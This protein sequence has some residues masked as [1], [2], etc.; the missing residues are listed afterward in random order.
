LKPIGTRPPDIS[1]QP[2]LS[3]VAVT[4]SQRGDD[5]LDQLLVQCMIVSGNLVSPED[6][7]STLKS[8]FGL[9]MG[10]ERVQRGLERLVAQRQ[11]TSS[12]GVA[13]FGVSLAL[14]GRIEA[15]IESAK[16]LEYRVREKWLA[17]CAAVFTKLD[18]DQ[19]WICLQRYL[20]MLFR[21]HGLQTV[22]LL[23][24]KAEQSEEHATLLKS[25]LDDALTESCGTGEQRPLVE[26]SIRLFLATVGSDLDRTKF[27]VQLADGAFSYYS[28]SAPPEVAQRLQAQLKELTLFLDTNFLLGLLGLHVNP[29]DAVSEELILVISK[30]K[31]PFKLRYHE[32]TL[33]EMCRTIVGISRQVDHL[34]I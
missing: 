20:S 12:S 5:V 32:A 21:R 18:T 33:V 24:T 28:L 9:D 8:L 11:I 13:G 19:A 30:N 25:S 16:K 22:L 23:D 34:S 17:Q 1:L 7:S 2:L 4:Q 27:I 6:F 29:L 15:R 14:R 10:L 3:F 31:L 26:R